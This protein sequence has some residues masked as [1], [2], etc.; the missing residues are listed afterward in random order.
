MTLQE[1]LSRMKPADS[2]NNT[3][4]A[5]VT[6]SPIANKINNSYDAP[7]KEMIL[8]ALSVNG[9]EKLVPPTDEELVYVSSVFQSKKFHVMDNV[10][11]NV[12]SD[13]GR[14]EFADL[15]TKL[16]AFTSKMSAVKTP[17]LFSLFNA[18]QKNISDADLEG[19]W[20]RSSKAKPTL[21]ARFKGLFNPSAEDESLNAQFRAMYEKLT[22]SGKGLEVEINKL[23]KQLITQKTQQEKNIRDLEDSYNIY[24]HSFIQLRKQF[25]L[26]V[27]LEQSYREQLENYKATQ[28]STEDLDFNKRLQ[29]Y[30]STYEDIQNRRLLLHSALLKLPITVKQNEQLVLVCKNLLKEIDITVQSS[31]PSIRSSFASLGI[32]LNAQQAMLGTESA[33][34]LEQQSQKMVMKVTGDLAVKSIQLSS[35]SRLKEAE[36]IKTLVTGLKDMN[37]R[38]QTAKDQSQSNLDQAS[39][40]LTEATEELKVILGQ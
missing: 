16:S 18:L 9:Y 20:E 22:A 26:I 11:F 28:V 4:V 1:R 21:M 39:D 19:L 30:Q 12:V 36:N 40:I 6:Q 15:N 3:V 29:D 38:I 7:R 32:A 14:A 5:T 35:E 27:Y 10:N 31:F 34:N 25:I 23:E 13:I 24:Y 17:G 8:S 33:K 2:G 37:D